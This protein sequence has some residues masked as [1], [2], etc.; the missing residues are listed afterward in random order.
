MSM[1][2]NNMLYIVEQWLKQS[3]HLENISPFET[4]LVL[5][6]GDLAQLPPIY[7]HIIWNNDILCKSCH[8][9]FASYW[10]KSK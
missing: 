8:I 9:K 3:I 6:V 4:K 10:K 2:T 7:R 1:M 5:I